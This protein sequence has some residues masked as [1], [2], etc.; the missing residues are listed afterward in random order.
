MALLCLLFFPYCP[1]R[2]LRAR[3]ELKKKKTTI[4]KINFSEIF[5][6]V[7]FILI[8][9]LLSLPKQL[10][11]KIQGSIL[12]HR[13]RFTGQVNQYVFMSPVYNFFKVFNIKRIGKLRIF[14]LKDEVIPEDRVHLFFYSF[15][16]NSKNFSGSYREHDQVSSHDVNERRAWGPS[17]S[18][19]NIVY[20]ENNRSFSPEITNCLKAL[21]EKVLW[22]SR[23][24]ASTKAK[25]ARASWL[26]LSS[27]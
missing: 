9:S 10:W 24:D 15:K 8:S 17:V 27:S 7:I 25:A 13:V 22:S 1:L 3:F 20:I 16:H 23:T 14:K 19:M 2:L 5:T 12:S 11:I 4:F 21:A 18:W 26:R 6:I